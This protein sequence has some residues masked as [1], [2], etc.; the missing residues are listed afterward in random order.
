[1]NNIETTE[2]LMLFLINLFGESF[3]Q[4]AILKG[5][6]TLRLLDS[7]RYTNELDYVFIPY[8]SKKEIEESI[9]KVLDDVDGLT[10]THNLNS[11]C[12]RIKVKYNNL[13]TQ[14]EVNVAED[15]PSVSV[16]TASM[17][18]NTGQLSR[19]VRIMDYS[20]S[21]AHKLAVWNERNLVRDLYDLYFYYVFLKILPDISTL[22]ERLKNIA[23]I[24]QNKNPK[25]MDMAAL[26]QKL[27]SAL[28]ALTTKD[29]N[30]LADYLPAED[31]PGLEMKLKTN[32]LKLCDEIELTTTNSQ[33]YMSVLQIP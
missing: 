21:M 4:S 3:P 25:V 28:Q 24:K 11:K 17:A 19:V 27:R 13:L 1:M 29:I 15:C 14:I 22:E 23:S 9:L 8:K 7:P 5:G 12:L 6:M 26:L 20:V 33:S 31:L 32:L 18:I 30:E 16:T 10:Y 2:E